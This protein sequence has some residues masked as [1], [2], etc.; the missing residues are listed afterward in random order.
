MIFT[1]LSPNTERDD[2]LLALKL[3]LFPWTR[4]SARGSRFK[5]ENEFLD[6]L[7]P[8]QGSAFAFDSGRTSLYAILKA[9]DLKKDD[10]VLLQAYTCVAVPEPVLW[11]G[12]KPVYVDV[13]DDF[14]MDPQDL[15]KKI[16]PR[17]KVLIIQHTFGLPARIDELMKIA[18]THNLF[19][20]EDC[21]HALG[22]EYKGKKVGTF[23][24]ASFFSFGRD[25]VISSVFGGMAF[26]QDAR[27]AEKVR[28]LYDSFPSSSFF[29]VQRQLHHPIIFAFA[30]ATYSLYIGKIIIEVS[31]RLRLFSVPVEPIELS[32]GRPSFAFKRMSD[33]LAALALYQF[34]KLTRFNAHRKTVAAIY[35]KNLPAV[36]LP[37]EDKE[38]ESIY[39]RFTLL[40]ES[41]RK[42]LDRM[43]ASGVY[44]G[45]WYWNSIAPKNVQYEKIQYDPKLTPRAEFLALRSLNL[46]T[47]IQISEKDAMKVAELVNQY[48]SSG[49]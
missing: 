19:V 37:E 45:D 1:S 7:S 32:G 39:L 28:T 18:R 27:V 11:V 47:G 33:M 6:L 10:E 48:A 13:L 12:A 20:I 25:K 23:G 24:D 43:K 3:H 2:I 26:V 40:V 38:R 34:K 15:I 35:R 14:T 30:K 16:S 46:P 5:L 17:A 31:K 8:I 41:P 49:N 21:A 36:M 4:R 29:W 22:A 44:L 42:I 9:L